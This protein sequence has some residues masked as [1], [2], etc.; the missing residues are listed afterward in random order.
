MADG[1]GTE[2]P[3]L[4][5][6]ASADRIRDEILRLVDLYASKAHAPRP[7]EAGA[8]PVPVSGR[9]YGAPEM[10]LLVD[11]AL[12]FWLTTGRFNAAFEG[13]LARF[14]GA[15][16]CLTCNSGS[17][18]NLLAVTAL[19]SHLLGDRRLVPGD[20]V[21][22]CATGF[23]TTVNPILQNG[24][25]PVFLDVEIPTYNL[26]VRAL[27]A[28]LSPRTRAIVVAHTL[29][30]PFDLGAVTA[31][32]KA[33]DLFLVEDCCDALGATYDGR[34]VGTFGDVGTLSFYPAHHITM[35]EGG[36]VF[37]GSSRLKRALESLRDWGRDCYCAPGQ[38]DT[39]KKRFDWKLGDL[40]HGYDH[41]Y[42]YSHLGY[43]LK[44]TD[45][46]AAVGVAQLD[47][48]DGFIAL[49]KR[50]YALLRDGLRRFED[51]L[52]L[53]E[54]TPL[55]EPSWFGF[56]L[57]LRESG[58]RNDLLKHLNRHRIGTRLLFGGNLTRQPYML[59]RRFR[60]V[61]Y[62]SAS[63]RVMNDTFWIGVYPGISP[64][65]IAYMVDSIG[66][67]FAG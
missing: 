41:K 29:G 9:V 18:A 65:A 11:S 27:E 8:S 20:E 42:T 61:G 45:M 19:T 17:S 66:A 30:N 63:D 13:R 7:F 4:D 59:E 55:S 16:Y 35:G 43:N 32:A 15:R 51:R 22:T 6:T 21:I 53:P 14:I 23:P 56:P 67:F 31:F 39:C 36:A 40:P 3:T 50:N 26:D 25:V 2:A 5:A 60:T 28:A 34:M 46:Q 10:R 54:A 44:I 49:R 62:L 47:R 48:L 52:I 33:H 38:D 57:T 1:D 58:R 37:A 12:E 24:L 64:D